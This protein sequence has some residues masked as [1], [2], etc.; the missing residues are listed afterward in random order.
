MESGKNKDLLNR[1]IFNVTIKSSASFN[2][3]KLN[4]VILMNST[5]SAEFTRRLSEEFEFAVRVNHAHFIVEL[6]ENQFEVL[7]W[8]KRSDLKTQLQMET[9]DDIR[10]H[11]FEKQ[12]EIY[13]NDLSI[14]PTLANYVKNT[15][16]KYCV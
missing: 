5:K 14:T 1:E 11:F 3:G 7:D 4:D 13:F 16:V 6:K 2:L 15:V 12:A 10:I 9:K 8:L